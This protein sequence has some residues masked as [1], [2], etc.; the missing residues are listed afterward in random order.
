MVL[1]WIFNAESLMSFIVE[2]IAISVNSEHR[3]KAESPIELA[4]EGIMICV[5]DEHSENVFNWSYRRRI[6][7]IC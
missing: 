5:N 4:E 7:D 2:R 6:C 3:E 1:S